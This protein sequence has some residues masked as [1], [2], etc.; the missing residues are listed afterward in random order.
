[1]GFQIFLDFLRT[2]LFIYVYRQYVMFARTSMT[3]MSI[4]S[5]FLH[6]YH[7]IVFQHKR[8]QID[9]NNTES[10]ASTN[11]EKFLCRIIY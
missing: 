2:F 1:M 10:L 5:L 9:N 7:I 8:R 4:F 3:K 11:N 6:F